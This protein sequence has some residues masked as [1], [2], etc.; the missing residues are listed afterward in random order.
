MSDW[1][2]SFFDASNQWDFTRIGNADYEPDLQQVLA[3]LIAPAVNERLPFIL[4]RLYS[5]GDYCFYVVA[6]DIKQLGELREIIQAYFG[7]T[8]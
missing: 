7:N 3:R 4:P 8:Y 6:G 5:D 1:P 2:A